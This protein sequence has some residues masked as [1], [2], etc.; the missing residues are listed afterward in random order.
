M[1]NNMSNLGCLLFLFIY[2]SVAVF[3]IVDGQPTTDDHDDNVD[4]LVSIVTRLQGELSRV[5]AEQNKSQEEIAKL[6]AELSTKKQNNCKLHFYSVFTAD[7]YTSSV[8][9]SFYYRK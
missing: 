4:Y 1:Y 2:S 5:Q 6:K 7:I 3:V 9:F 8:P